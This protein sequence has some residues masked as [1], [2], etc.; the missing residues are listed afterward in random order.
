MDK[1]R[2]GNKD[3]DSYPTKRWGNYTFEKRLTAQQMKPEKKRGA[4]TGHRILPNAWEAMHA[5]T[6]IPPNTGTANN[7]HTRPRAA[8]IPQKG[9]QSMGT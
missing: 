7:V 4:H 6:E 1:L 9:Q 8:A 3:P 2:L 5:H